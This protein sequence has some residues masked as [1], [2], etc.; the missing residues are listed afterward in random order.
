[1]SASER[2][3]PA[4]PVLGYCSPAS[5]H[6]T[7]KNPEASRS[8]RVATILLFFAGLV[9]IVWSVMS[10]DILGGVVA[11]MMIVAWVGLSIAAIRFGAVGFKKSREPNVEGAAAA[12]VGFSIGS[13]ALAV[14]L[15]QLI[16]MAARP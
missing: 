13:I 2:Q 14:V 9:P 6:L 12:A 7:L 4:V 15:F 8:L 1:M 11:A 3:R 5:P 10:H 16:R